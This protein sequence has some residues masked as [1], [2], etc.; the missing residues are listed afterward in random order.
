MARKAP[1]IALSQG[2]REYLQ[3]V[4][5]RYTTEHREVLRAR[6]ILLA[7]VDNLTIHK[8]Q[9]VKEYLKEREDCIFLHFTPHS[10]FLAESN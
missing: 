10:C 6:I 2:E 8:H 7:I 3:A 1:R 4:I 9:K 5:T